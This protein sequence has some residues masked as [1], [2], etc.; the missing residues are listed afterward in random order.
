MKLAYFPKQIAQNAPPILQAILDGA[1]RCGFQISSDDLEADTAL[2]WSVLWRGRMASNKSVY[3]HYR[4]LGRPVIVVDVGALCR[5]QTW[6]V[7]LNHINSQG[8]YGHQINLDPDRPKKLGIN[9]GH[10]TK[11]NPAII[12]AAQ[13]TN[14]LQVQ[15]VNLD[16]WLDD[17]IR[18]IRRVCD[19][20]LILRPHPRCRMDLQRF[21][22]QGLEIQSPKPMPD[23]Y[24]SFDFDLSYHAVVNYNSG[25]G[26][27]AAI[28]GTRP[29]VDNSSLAY[30]V[31]VEIDAIEQPYDHDREQW[32]IEVS[33]TEYT[34]EELAL[35]TWAS[36]LGL[37]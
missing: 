5:G 16:N 19:R 2:I 36:R 26:I 37:I 35:G 7:A 27:Q 24:D 10:Q 30:P 17:R 34:T 8:Y 4:N 25:P 13:H 9:L 31:S 20:P 3:R 22:R 1:V 23:T 32:L 12:L 11:P 28:A 6:K 29:I 33:H 21:Q 15:T 14:S 18:A